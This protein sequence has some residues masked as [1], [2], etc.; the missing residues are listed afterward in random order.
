MSTQHMEVE[1]LC[2]SQLSQEVVSPE[3]KVV[4][5]IFLLAEGINGV[6]GRPTGKND[7]IIHIHAQCSV[8]CFP[9]LRDQGGGVEG[10][11]D[12]ED[13][14]ALRRPHWLITLRGHGPVK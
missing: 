13:R 5:A 7:T 6:P 1:Q 12:R 4:H 2:L 14:R 9:G 10:R 11:E 8:W 3:P